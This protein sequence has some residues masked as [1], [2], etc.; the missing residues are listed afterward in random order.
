MSEQS[1]G[2]F[3][4]NWFKLFFVALCLFLIALYFY[5]EDQLDKCLVHAHMN[6][7]ANWES[8][9]KQGKDGAECSLPRLIAD[10][11]EKGREKQVDECFKRY[12]FKN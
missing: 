6:Y 4:T 3:A 8:Q 1:K 5:R 12:S 7:K 2:F 10:S 11:L 9:C